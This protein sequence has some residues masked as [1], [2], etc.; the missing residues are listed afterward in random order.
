MS[1]D[2]K[3][4]TACSQLAPLSPQRNAPSRE[5]TRICSSGVMVTPRML[6]INDAN[7]ACFQEVPLSVETRTVVLVAATKTG[8]FARTEMK[9][10]VP[11][12]G[13]P[14][15]VLPCLELVKMPEAVAASQRSPSI[16]TSLTLDSSTDFSGIRVV[17]TVLFLP[18]FTV[19]V[20][21]FSLTMELIGRQ[22]VP[23]TSSMNMPRFVPATKDPLVLCLRLNTSRPWRPELF[24]N[25][26]RPPSRDCMSPLYSRSLTTPTYIICGSL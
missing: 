4:F 7:G 24:C 18:F 5:A 9:S 3:P 8:P 26:L 19:L 1:F 16:S 11:M 14:C 20:T 15:Q 21:T 23:A 17:A 12:T 10:F 6:V 22:V 2:G 13:P 25:Q